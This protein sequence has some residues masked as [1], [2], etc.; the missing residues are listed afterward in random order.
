VLRAI[1]SGRIQ[2]D[3]AESA[4]REAQ[5]VERGD[6]IVV[7]VNRFQSD[8]PAAIELQRIDR[9]VAERQLE[10]LR[11]IRRDRDS[12]SVRSALGALGRAARTSENLM[13]RIL[14]AVKVYATLGEICD[15]LREAF[16]TYRPPVI[17]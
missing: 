13:P 9:D 3:I 12:A 17:V 15:V 6:Q 1:E 2:R 11:G 7:G 14:D 4:Y 16:S 10:R 8:R 5:A